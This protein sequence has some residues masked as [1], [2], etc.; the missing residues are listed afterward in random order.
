MSSF[1]R[2]REALGGRLR[3]LRRDA[4]LTGKQLAE[5]LSWQPSKISRI[6]SGKQTPSDQDLEEWAGGCGYPDQATDLIA[7]LRNLEGHYIEHR[8]KFR[9]GK[10]PGQNAFAQLESRTSF[11][12][13]FENVVVPGLLQTA[14]YARHR[15]LYGAKYQSGTND[16]DEAVAA[17]MQRQQT[18]YRPDKR[19]H[20]IVTEAVV[21]YRLCPPDVLKGQL[22]RLL[23]LATMRNIDLG[24]IPFDA[25]YEIKSPLHGFAI[26]DESEVRVETL[27]LR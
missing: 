21:R 5:S 22:D 2:E 23:G 27:R 24:V 1:Q 16:I 13:N 10:A 15:F 8:R 20:F 4:R 18:L 19:F 14:E 7:A 11:V 6:E 12:R 9:A 26:Y 3:E 25:Q 17:R